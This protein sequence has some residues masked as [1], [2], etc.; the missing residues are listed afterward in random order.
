MPDNVTLEEGAGLG[1]PAM[2]AYFSLFADGPLDGLD[3]LVT[4]GAGACG[5]YAV[6]FARLAGARPS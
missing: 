5:L 4:G 6:Q 3:V 1:V 2:T